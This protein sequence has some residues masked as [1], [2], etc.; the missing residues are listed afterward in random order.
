MRLMVD[1]CFIW[2]TSCYDDTSVILQRQQATS[3]P[4]TSFFLSALSTVMCF[5]IW[6]SCIDF[7]LNF[8]IK[9]S[10]MS[11]KR[12]KRHFLI[13]RWVKRCRHL[14]NNILRIFPHANPFW[15]YS[16]LAKQFI[17]V[18]YTVGLQPKLLDHITH[19]VC[20]DQINKFQ[21]VLETPCEC[22]QLEIMIDALIAPSPIYIIL[23]MTANS[24][25][26]APTHPP[27]HTHTTPPLSPVLWAKPNSFLWEV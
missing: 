12:E 14:K 23:S 7:V 3:E 25:Q 1:V 21:L 26:R 2:N 5:H 17:M 6:S 16:F 4:N 27:K 18:P 9:A 10:L 19:S 22:W 20:K 15:I 24:D 13:R 11:L 8:K